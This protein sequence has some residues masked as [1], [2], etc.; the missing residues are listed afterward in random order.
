M[1]KKALYEKYCASQ[2][3]YYTKDIHDILSNTSTTNTIKIKDLQ[4]YDDDQEYFKRIY[5][6][7][8]Y[9]DKMDTLVEYYR[10]H[11]DIPRLFMLPITKALNKYHDK[12]RK[13][14]YV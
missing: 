13:Y 12:K 4:T 3:Y 8:Q 11:Q 14:V 6:R 1:I 5:Y 10:Y 7:S 2:S 9:N